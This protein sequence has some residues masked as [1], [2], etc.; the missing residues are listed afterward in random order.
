[1]ADFFLFWRIL[2]DQ[3]PTIS[4]LLVSFALNFRPPLNTHIDQTNAEAG[5]PA[6]AA[7]GGDFLSRPQLFHGGGRW[8]VELLSLLEVVLL[9]MMAIEGVMALSSSTP[10]SSSSTWE[11]VPAR[12]CSRTCSVLTAV[13]MELQWK[14]GKKNRE[15]AIEALSIDSMCNDSKVPNAYGIC[16]CIIVNLKMDYHEQVVRPISFREIEG[17]IIQ[18]K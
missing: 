12:C 4:L 13:Q 14:C 10:S 7:I 15:N 9:P 17:Q 2:S 11:L 5:H 3:T 6:P 16:M 1:M 8:L 18:I